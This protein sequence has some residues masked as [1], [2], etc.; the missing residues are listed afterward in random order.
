MAKNIKKP[1]NLKKGFT[2]GT[3]ALTLLT[4]I[5]G[6]GIAACKHDPDPDPTPDPKPEEKNPIEVKFNA[7][8]TNLGGQQITL[9]FPYGFAK[10]RQDAIKAKFV[11]AL[12][13]MD[14]AAG[15]P[16]PFKD[17]ANAVL[18]KGLKIIIEDTNSVSYYAKVVDNKLVVETAWVEDAV[19]SGG[20]IASEIMWQ[21]NNDKLTQVLKLDNNVKQFLVFPNA[22]IAAAYNKQKTA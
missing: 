21:I 12:N 5:A 20:D 17:K 19:V 1:V 10:A 8:N 18:D 3:A 22:E 14:T 7:P 11:A 4:L 15:A 9:V 16:G 13:D 2:R 6:L